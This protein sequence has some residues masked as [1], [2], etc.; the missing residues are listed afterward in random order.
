MLVMVRIKSK[1][2]DF[3]AN[4]GKFDFASSFLER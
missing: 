1:V 2:A 4:F 3:Y